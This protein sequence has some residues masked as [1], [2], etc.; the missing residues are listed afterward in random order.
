MQIVHTILINLEWG[1]V[2]T[3]RQGRAAKRTPIRVHYRGE[4]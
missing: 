3:T 4:R 1:S 2:G